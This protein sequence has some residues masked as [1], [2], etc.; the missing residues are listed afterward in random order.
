MKK[1]NTAQTEVIK[2]LSYEIASLKIALQTAKQHGVF[3]S[4]EDILEEI[5]QKV[6]SLKFYLTGDEEQ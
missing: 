5:T 3:A 2:S 6:E 1:I 4:A